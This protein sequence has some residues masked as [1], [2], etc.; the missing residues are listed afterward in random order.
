MNKQI[1]M[2]ENCKELTRISKSNIA[3]FSSIIKELE[4]QIKG[5]EEQIHCEEAKL[6]VLESF[7][8]IIE[9]V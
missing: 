1:T 8:T 6:Q 3:K 5:F 2:H 7:E 4:A 9:S